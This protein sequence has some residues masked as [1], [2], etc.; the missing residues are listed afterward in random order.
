M[1]ETFFCIWEDGV[2]I[3]IPI[4]PVKYNENP[5]VLYINKE[6]MSLKGGE[7]RADWLVTL[8]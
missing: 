1:T 6:K 4:P 7:T 5:S 2:D 3:L 8:G